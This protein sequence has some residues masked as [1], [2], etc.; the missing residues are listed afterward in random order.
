LFTANDLELRFKSREAERPVKLDAEVRRQVF[1]IFK[2][3]AHN[4]VRHARCSRVDIDV[5]IENHAISLTIT[6]DGKGFDTGQASQGH[7]LSS[8][9]HRTKTLGGTL[10]IASQP[11]LGT[12]VKLRIP[13]ARHAT[14][15]R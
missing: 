11:H 4:V 10:E 6:D 1:L 7:G 13:L 14:A 3:C 2:E 5:R 12:S 9:A 15:G 8:M